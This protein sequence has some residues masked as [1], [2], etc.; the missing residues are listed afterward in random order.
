MTALES[1]LTDVQELRRRTRELIGRGAPT[2]SCQSDAKYI[3]DILNHAL[4]ME[5]LCVL[6]YRQHYFSAKAG[7]D[8]SAAGEFLRH[9]SE[10]QQHADRI[11]ECI[12]QLGGKPNFNPS[13]LSMHG[14]SEYAERTELTDLVKE[15]LAAEHVAIQTYAEVLLFIEGRD[16]SARRLIEDILAVEEEHAEEMRDSLQQLQKWIS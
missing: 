1:F 8:S 6:R 16:P 5:L 3:C 9:A 2:I 7:N 11:A 14:C 13:G 12:A 4:A 15:D 10:E